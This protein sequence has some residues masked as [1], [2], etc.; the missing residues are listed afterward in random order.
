MTPGM[1]IDQLFNSA[2][3]PSTQLFHFFEYYFIVRY[4]R[5]RATD[6]CLISCVET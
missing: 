3:T 6:A 1:H 5:E 2:K 4:N